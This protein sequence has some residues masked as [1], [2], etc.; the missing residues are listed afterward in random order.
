M[1]I[2]SLEAPY[3]KKPIRFLDD[4]IWGGWTLKVDGIAYDVVRPADTLMGIARGIAAER[5]AQSA[6]DCIQNSLGFVGIHQGKTGNFVFV[7]WCADE[8]ALL[9]HVYVSPV[10]YP[11]QFEYRTPSGLTAC[12]CDLPVICHEREDWLESVL[13]S[14]QLLDELGYLENVFNGEV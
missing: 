4:W 7:D 12:V 1:D 14:Y 11:E 9:H 13:K 10:E 3:Q 6:G 5:L 8:N 2:V